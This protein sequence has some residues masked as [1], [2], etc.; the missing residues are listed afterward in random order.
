MERNFYMKSDFTQISIEEVRMIGSGLIRPKGVM[1]ADDGNIYTTDARGCCARISPEGDTAFF[2]TLGGTPNGLCLDRKGNCIIA[3]MSNGRV[4]LL[5]GDGSQ[6][7]LL[8]DPQDDERIFSPNSPFLDLQGRL[9]ISCSTD[10]PYREPSLRSPVPDG[11]L[12]V[13]ENDKEPRI[14]AD[15]MGFINGV[16]LDEEEKFVYVAE[17]LNMRILR[18]PI[19]EDGSLGAKEVYGPEVLGAK[20]VPDGIAFDEAGNL[21]VTFPAANAVGYITPDRKLGIFVEDPQGLILHAP[22]SICFGGKNRKTAFIGSLRNSYIAFFDVPF[23]G[24]RL[25]HQNG[26]H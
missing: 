23:P 26:L 1:V 19:N 3:N 16:A 25:I 13:L 24:V 21:W 15:D 11:C 4:Q 2:G 17:T 9:W 5:A 7:V 12:I 18:Y 6:S 20:Y 22:A 14:A 8:D 10:Y